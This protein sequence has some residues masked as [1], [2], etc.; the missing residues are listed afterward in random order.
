MGLAFFSLNQ[1]DAVKRIT[2]ISLLIIY[3]FLPIIWYR[4]VR[5]ARKKVKG[6]D[7]SSSLVHLINQFDISKREVEIIELILE[8]LSNKEIADRLHISLHTVK[9]HVYNIYGKLNINSR[10][11]LFS[12]MENENQ[13]K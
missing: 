12:I 10:Y 2:I 11:M 3:S 1:N 8:G 13:V 4:L 9:N 7:H 6:Q 5:S